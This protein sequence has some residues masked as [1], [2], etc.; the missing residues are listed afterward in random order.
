MQYSTLVNDLST[1]KSNVNYEELCK[2]IF[3]NYQQ[4]IQMYTFGMTIRPTSLRAVTVYQY[5]TGITY[6]TTH[7]QLFDYISSVSP[8]DF[9]FQKTVYATTSSVLNMEFVKLWEECAPDICNKYIL[10]LA[11]L[12]NGNDELIKHI[13]SKVEKYTPMLNEVN[14]YENVFKCFKRL[15]EIYEPRIPVAPVPIL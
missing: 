8:H 1:L 6:Y 13:V 7:D 3:E 11:C 9:I 10:K 5:S 12:Q 14:I 2:K 15:E 4:V